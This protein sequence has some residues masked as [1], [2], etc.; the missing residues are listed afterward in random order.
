M[1][2]Q[3]PLHI[4]HCTWNWENWPR[5]FLFL[6]FLPCLRSCT[7]VLLTNI[8][9]VDFV[10]AGNVDEQH[11]RSYS[12]A[13]GSCRSYS[14][15]CENCKEKGDFFSRDYSATV[16]CQCWFFLTLPLIFFFLLAVRFACQGANISPTRCNTNISWWCFGKVSTVL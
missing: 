16:C 3:F 7:G 6:N 4:F 8:S 10:V 1:W 11:R 2:I 9:S 15:S 13:G 5:D 12:W 14:Y